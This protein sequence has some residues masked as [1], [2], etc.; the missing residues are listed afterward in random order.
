MP[1][2]DF[3]TDAPLD[4]R[5]QVLLDGLLEVRRDLR[6]DPLLATSWSCD[7][8]RCRPRMGRHLCC[9]VQRRCPHLEGERCTI[10]SDK[11][12]ACEL[13][14]L[15]L[16][17]FGGIRVVTTVKNLDFFHTGWSRYDRDMLRCFEGD[18]RS[19]T[20][21]F[22]AQRTVLERVLTRSEVA[23]IDRALTR[24]RRYSASEDAGP[25]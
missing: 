3:F 18:E 11:P 22:E 17:R 24:L 25:R 12:F 1:P 10:Q 19:P 16:V 4:F 6:V 2:D 8:D 7:P 15:D 23:V 9:K 21:M 14:P 20:S 13:F 5:S